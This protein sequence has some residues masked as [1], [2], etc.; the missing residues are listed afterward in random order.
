[1]ASLMKTML[2][3][4]T[5]SYSTKIIYDEVIPTTWKLSLWLMSDITYEYSILLRM[6]W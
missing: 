4:G 2:R 6:E 5:A 1:M 3:A